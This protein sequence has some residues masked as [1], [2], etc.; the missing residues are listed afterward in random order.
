MQQL[1]DALLCL[2]VPPYCQW[3]WYCA[4]KQQHNCICASSGLA[5][6]PFTGI[7]A[8]FLCRCGADIV[9]ADLRKKDCDSL[10]QAVESMGRRGL[11]VECDVR[12]RLS[13]DE[14][15]KTVEKWVQP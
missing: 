8:W 12:D 2:L 3:S 6:H 5:K 1:T 15:I 14:S 7:S 11:F 4:K 13:V 10:L 9:A